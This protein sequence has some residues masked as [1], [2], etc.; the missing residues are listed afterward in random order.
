MTFISQDLLNLTSELFPRVIRMVVLSALGSS[1]PEVVSS[2][3]MFWRELLLGL[4]R[5]SVAVLVTPRRVAVTLGDTLVL[6][7]RTSRISSFPLFLE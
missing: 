5:V 6:I 2:P 1:K 3:A 4:E 7:R